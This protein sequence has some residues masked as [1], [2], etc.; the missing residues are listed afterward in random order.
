[1]VV[2]KGKPLA[3]KVNVDLSEWH[4]DDWTYE[5]S[6]DARAESE[7]TLDNELIIKIRPNINFTELTRKIAKEA[8]E[9]FLDLSCIQYCLDKNQE[10]LT[11][12]LELDH[13][14]S[15]FMLDEGLPFLCIF[16]VPMTDDDISTPEDAEMSADEI[17][18]RLK[19]AGN[20]LVKQL[21]KIRAALKEL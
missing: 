20:F 8:I 5:L 19:M 15:P 4:M 1:M 3:I 13:H 18:D 17:R 16:G 10:Y 6:S 7:I 9:E 14:E 11:A 12:R 21:E 2:K